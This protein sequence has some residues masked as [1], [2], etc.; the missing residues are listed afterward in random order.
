MRVWGGIVGGDNGMGIRG[1]DRPG[2]EAK[3]G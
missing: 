2:I 3:W 1:L